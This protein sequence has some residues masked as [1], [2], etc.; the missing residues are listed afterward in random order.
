MTVM[1]GT[2]R[3]T[4]RSASRANARRS[5]L[6]IAALALVALAPATALAIGSE[7]PPNQA[8]VYLYDLANIWQPATEARAQ[9]VAEAI[10]SRTKAT[11]VV[12]SW[13]TGFDSV[14]TGTAR[15]D[16]AAI[17][18]AW[19][20]GRRG[21]NDGLVVLFDMDTSNRHG[22]IFLYAGSGFL[23][24][25]LNEAEASSIVN[26]DMLPK[27]KS[28]DFDGALL[29]GIDHL[30]RIIQPGGN[31]ER[32]SWALIRLSLSIALAVAGGALLGRF[33]RAWWLR[34]RD[35][36]TPL[37]DASVLLPDPPPGL[38]PAMA[39]V[40]REDMVDRAAFTS[41]LVDLGHRGLVT[42]QDD[43]GDGKKVD[44]HVPR[45]PLADIGS[46]EAR[47]RPLGVAE[48]SLAQKIE[49]DGDPDG[50]GWTITAK[51]LRAGTG[52]KLYEDFK[53]H[54]GVAAGS[55]GWFR[56]DPNKLMGKWAGIGTLVAIAAPIA[57][58]VFGLADEGSPDILK[59][60]Y[61]PLAAALGFDCL[62]GIVIAIGS[63]FL[64]ART[65]DGARTL[66]MALAYR[67]T[68]EF[69]IAQAPTVTAAVEA[70]KPRLPWIT[71][72]DLLTVWAV[73]LGLNHEIDKLIK[74]T[75]ETQGTTGAGVWT[76]FW[77]S[78]SLGGGG[79]SSAGLAGAVSSISVSATS[80][81]GG[82]FGGGGSGGGG[83]A[84][85]GF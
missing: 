19:G 68:L 41:A 1:R 55:S 54:I 80:S 34:G 44:L 43:E 40:L 8:G 6:A 5:V 35:A 22:Q 78:G 75:M 32:A 59:P 7:L 42:F 36:R 77:F 13:P 29:A 74:R 46:L 21:I 64:P 51:R 14:S 3:T 20:V 23:D 76:P 79:F 16:A 71:T 70:T 28:G 31:P 82:G 38:T 69:E 15:T 63:R 45:E 67:N 37:I 73:A 50:E 18:D 9:Q 66:A 81:S 17:M 48:H 4:P 57:L 49:S 11:V 60:G 52:A 53:K 26:G 25:W 56:D 62:I 12:V 2:P 72:P 85:G 39:T 61:E 47:R 58:A 65:E 27:A 33:L 83:G 30:D 10:R 84:G 24:T